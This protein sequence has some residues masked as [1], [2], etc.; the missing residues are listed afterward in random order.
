TEEKNQA[1]LIIADELE[2][3]TD[4]ILNENKKDLERG[5]EKGF[6]E[7][8]MDRLSLSKERVKDFANGLREVAD[9]EDPVGEVISDWSLD[10]GMQVE[11]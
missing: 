6:T 1:L 4:Y 10:N 11:Q 8:F 9:L 5:K 7:A 3:E 2:K